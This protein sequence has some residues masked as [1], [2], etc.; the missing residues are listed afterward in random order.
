MAIKTLIIPIGKRWLNMKQSNFDTALGWCLMVFLVG[1]IAIG[2]N[3]LYLI[4]TT[5]FQ[6]IIMP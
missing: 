5:N 6:A 1:T 3:T 4:N 2:L